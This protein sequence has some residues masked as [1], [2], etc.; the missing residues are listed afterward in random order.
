MSIELHVC[1]LVVQVKPEKMPDVR[2]AI[3]VMKDTELSVN[4][5]IKLV[6]VIEGE[7]R[8]QVME[9]VDEINAIPGVISTSVVYQQSEVLEEDEI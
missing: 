5:E 6:V 7:R 1:S 9:R 3:M 2:Q 8:K 4:N